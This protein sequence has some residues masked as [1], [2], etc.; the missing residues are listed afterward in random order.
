MHHATGEAKFRLDPEIEIAQ[1]YGLS[2]NRV[3]TAERMIREREDEVRAAWNE[4]FGR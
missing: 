1:N 2:P 3:N 4:H